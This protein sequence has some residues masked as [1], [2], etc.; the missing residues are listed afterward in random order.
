MRAATEVANARTIRVRSDQNRTAEPAF[1]FV[2]C[3]QTGNY[4]DVQ[5]TRRQFQQP[6]EGAR[7]SRVGRSRT[8]TAYVILAKWQLA[9][10]VE[11]GYQ[12]AG[13]DEKLH[14]GG[15]HVVDLM[16]DGRARRDDGLSGMTGGDEL[17]RERRGPV[18]AA[19]RFT[20]D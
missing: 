4:R 8:S 6:D 10:V 20:V 18:L 12:R 3:A 9:I 2:I 14:A 13:D 16:N 5:V 15:S 1:I 17:V 11:Q 19:V 7:S